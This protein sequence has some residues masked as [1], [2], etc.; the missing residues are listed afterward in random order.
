M[1]IEKKYK[2]LINARNFHYENFNKWMTYFYV[3]IGALFL[4]YCT[5]TISVNG[6]ASKRNLLEYSISI[7]G[8]IVG[9][10]WYWSCKGYYYWNI[11]FITLVNYYEETLLKLPKEERI[12]YVF[13]NKDAQNNY[14]SPISGANISTSKIA[15]FFSFIV[16]SAW[17][18]IPFYKIITDASCSNWFT[19][20]SSIIYSIVSVIIISSV[21]PKKWLQSK[22]D[23][24][25]DLKLT[26]EKYN[27][28]EKTNTNNSIIMG[29]DEFILYMRKNGRGM[30]TTN[31]Q[32]G[33]MIWNWI[34]ENA[35][36][37]IIEER[38]DEDCRWGAN[39]NHVDEYDLPKTA[40]Q[41]EFDRVFLPE[42]Y[43]YLDS[44]N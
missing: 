5:I 9:L 14:S 3:A 40:T 43:S 20:L 38:R 18:F 13:A 2:I 31:D 44:I 19:I 22:I 36:G 37:V 26:Q 41:I 28:D 4:G 15:I 30:K 35:N 7:L 27:D 33:K 42:L 29:N 25:P 32:L 8:Y 24:F 1:N 12:Y 6:D 34:K 11:N 21:I 23:H 39:A 17:G 10:L 16:T